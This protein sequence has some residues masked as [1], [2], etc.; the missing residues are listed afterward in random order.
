VLI[1]AP[2]IFGFSDV[3][4]AKWTAIG[5]GVAV[6]ASSIMTNYEWGLVRVIPMHVHLIADAALGVFLAASPWILGFS[7]EGTNV[8]LPHLLVG[9]GEIG[10]AAMSNPWPQDAEARRR[11]ERV[12]HRTA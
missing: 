9:L 5:V 6:L 8:W 7:D 12:V 1:V 2:W 11:E 4:S 10:V 3:D